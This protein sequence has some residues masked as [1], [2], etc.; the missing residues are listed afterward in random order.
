MG[1]GSFLR[2]KSFRRELQRANEKKKKIKKE[3]KKLAEIEEMKARIKKE[4]GVTGLSKAEK[5]ALKNKIDR[6]EVRKKVIKDGLK[7]VGSELKKG[8]ISF[9]QKLDEGLSNMGEQPRRKTT[10]KKKSKTK[11][12]KKKRKTKQKKKSGR[13]K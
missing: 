7:I 3:V 11:S 2:E 4:M 1:L 12:K 9:L 13:K 10:R 6:I 5:V 8:A